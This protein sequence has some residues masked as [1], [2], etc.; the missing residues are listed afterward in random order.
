MFKRIC[1][2]FLSFAA[3]SCTKLV[4]DQFPEHDPVPVLN[5]T[6]IAGQ[7]I[8]LNLSFSSK[9]DSTDYIYVESATVSLF[10]EG[11]FLEMLEYSGNG[12]YIAEHVVQEEVNYSC[13]IVIE[14]YDTIRASTFVPAKSSIKSL[15]HTSNA[16][17]TSEGVRY[18]SL[19]VAFRNDTCNLQY[20]ELS[21][22]GIE[23]D[24]SLGKIFLINITDPIIL[25]EGIAEAVFSNEIIEDSICQMHLNFHGGHASRSR[26]E[27]RIYTIYP[28]QIELRS[29]SKEY[30]LFRKSYYL[31]QDGRWGDGIITPMGSSSIYS[32]VENGYGIFSAYSAT[33]PVNIEPDSENY[34]D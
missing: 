8:N 10:T 25:N 12:N 17:Y 5:A 1:I 11:L 9:V 29:I 27:P 30:Y 34:Y 24:S 26:G 4:T 21:I 3:S 31:Y 32:N 18:P 22:K 14:G 23:N 28:L 15:K 6:L 13:E 2:I 20:Y 7:A 33:K 16:G 19:N